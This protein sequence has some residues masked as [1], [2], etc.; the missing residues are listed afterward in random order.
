MNSVPFKAGGALIDKHATVYI[1]GQANRQAVRHL[2]AM[3]YLLLIEPRQQGKTSLINYLMRHPTLDHTLLAY[4]DVTT[5]DRSTEATWYQTLCP[6]ILRQLRHVIPRKQWP[7]IPHNSA[8]WRD[9]L[10]FVALFAEK[11]ERRVVV[12]LDEIGAVTF[13]GAT[14]F[15]SVL[16]DIYNS[17]QAEPELKQLTF[18]LAGAFDPRDLI[19]GDKVSPFNIA[20]R[21][22]LED[23][24]LGQVHELVSKGGWL[25]EQSAAL[26]ER[27]HYWT[28][29]LPYLTQLLCSYLG[30]D[31]TPIE[32]DASVE[33]LRREDENHLRPMLGRLDGD[34]KLRRYVNQIHSGQRIKFYPP[35][36]QLQTQL[37]L[38]GVLKADASGYCIILNRI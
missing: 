23:F 1:E 37:E 28:D 34:D 7:D 8:G 5:P 2:Q 33:R 26:A 30:P 35:E 6:R 18:L 22:R 31:A 3:D 17:R 11:A 27:I 25:D 19:Q 36:N 14:D 16:R 29:G 4:L 12:A 24:T 9:F 21:V 10:T 32:V 13:P 38:L 20:E 15:F